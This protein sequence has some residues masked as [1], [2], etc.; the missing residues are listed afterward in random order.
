M[1]PGIERVKLWDT[2]VSD[3]KKWKI[4]I[5]HAGENLSDA[6]ISK[7]EEKMEYIED[8][9]NGRMI[10]DA[11]EEFLTYYGYQRGEK[12][13]VSDFERN[14]EDFKMT[15]SSVRLIIY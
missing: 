1:W 13:K 14:F 6:L 10:G 4:V 11:F 9:A 2:E 8:L 15:H 5:T 7:E 3:L 12:V